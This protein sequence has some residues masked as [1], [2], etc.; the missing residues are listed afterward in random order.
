MRG[1]AEIRDGGSP[2]ARSQPGRTDPVRMA[3]RQ[4]ST[5]HADSSGRQAETL[6]PRPGADMLILLS[7]PGVNTDAMPT[8]REPPTSP[9]PSRGGPVGHHRR[10]ASGPLSVG[11]ARLGR[12]PPD[13]VT[14]SRR[15]RERSPRGC[16]PGVPVARRMMCSRATLPLLTGAGRR[17]PSCGGAERNSTPRL[18]ADPAPHHRQARHRGPRARA[19]TSAALP[20]CPSARSMPSPAPRRCWTGWPALLRRHPRPSRSATASPMRW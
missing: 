13:R 3:S 7:I 6:P 17:L 20:A 16:C 12:A 15:P 10:R 2:L 8:P 11:R 18:R 4:S 14:R 1:G 19:T 9:I 5:S